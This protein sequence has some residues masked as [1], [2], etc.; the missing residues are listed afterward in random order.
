[1]LMTDQLQK[2]NRTN[3]TDTRNVTFS[4]ALEA[5]LTHYDYLDGRK[6]G[7]YL[8]AAALA[9]HSVSPAKAKE[10]KTSDTFGPLF[11]GLSPKNDLQQSLE[12][13]LRQAMAVNGCQEYVLTWKRWDMK[14]GP[15]I[16]ALRA[17]GRR[18]S[19]KGYSGWPTP[20]TPNGGRATPPGTSTTG[21][22]PDGKKRQVDL[23]HVARSITGWPT[24][25]SRDWKDTPGMATEGTNPDG[26][27]RT[28]MDQ[29]PRVAQQVSGL[30]PSPS[31]AP[32]ES[33]EG[34]LAGWLNTEVTHGGDGGRPGESKGKNDTAEKSREGHGGLSE[35][36]IGRKTGGVPGRVADS[37]SN[38]LCHIDG[39]KQ[40]KTESGTTS[41]PSQQQSKTIPP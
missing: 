38:G 20:N 23:Q 7:R 2:S 9:S 24:A 37:S 30:I 31:P 26:S 18:I 17:S 41:R 22:T 40:E 19:G 6:T 14:S 12:N 21:K 10:L 28:R 4:Q 33:G 36:G 8:R 3:L 34:C 27:K 32:M 11:D 25:S 29:L 16:C 35:S 1:M 5:G 13:R 39:V 15:P